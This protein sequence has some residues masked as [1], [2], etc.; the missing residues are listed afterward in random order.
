MAGRCVI[1]AMVTNDACANDTNTCIPSPIVNRSGAS[2]ITNEE[3]ALVAN[4]A[5]AGWHYGASRCHYM[6]MNQAW[7]STSTPLRQPISGTSQGDFENN[8]LPVV[9]TKATSGV[10]WLQVAAGNDDAN[11][12][13][14]GNEIK[15]WQDAH[16]GAGK[17]GATFVWS[18]HHEPNSAGEITTAGSLSQAGANYIAATRH[19]YDIWVARGV[20]IWQG[21]SDWTTTQ[22][23]MIL[24]INLIDGHAA[25]QDNQNSKQYFWGPATGA[26][27]GNAWM[28]D[29]CIMFAYDPYPVASFLP[30]SDLVTQTFAGTP[31]KTW[32]ANKRAYQEGRGMPFMEGIF[33]TGIRQTYQ[34]STI[35]NAWLPAYGA[36][37]PS[38]W[39]INMRNYIRDSWPTLNLLCWWDDSATGH[40]EID[41]TPA[42]FATAVTIFQDQTTF[43]SAL[44]PLPTGGPPPP[45][46][47]GD[48]VPGVVPIQMRAKMGA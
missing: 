28:D 48:F 1:G 26:G 37:N 10:S 38:N 5:P 13:A 2:A 46:P 30:L 47:G 25:N 11:I 44:T 7:T 14:R 32:G 3:A 27:A 21:Q 41:R 40:Y 9:T 43:A 6:F 29:H 42:E 8:R 33:E 31:V 34:Y 22:E 16:R 35:G 36:A 19:I 39:I 20:T 12:I 23:G 24:A 4:G 15:A 18:F 45:P 17:W